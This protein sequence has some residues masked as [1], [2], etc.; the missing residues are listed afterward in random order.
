[1]SWPQPIDLSVVQTRTPGG[2]QGK[3]KTGRQGNPSGRKAD[4]NQQGKYFNYRRQGHW[5]K[6]CRQPKKE[7]HVPVQVNILDTI[8]RKLLPVPE[9]ERQSR[10]DSDTPSDKI[11][12]A[13]AI[14]QSLL[15]KQEH[16][17][18]EDTTDSTRSASTD[19]SNW[20]L[21]AELP[22]LPRQHKDY[23]SWIRVRLADIDLYCTR[24]EVDQ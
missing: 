18:Q 10:E 16:K 19:N 21:L 13:R 8:E 3:A 5:A 9:Q 11:R 24:T 7:Q 2:R 1:V 4:K 6:K 15:D 22:I 17:L 12:L 23:I 14:T 20:G